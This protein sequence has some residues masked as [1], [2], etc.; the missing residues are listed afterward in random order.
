MFNPSNLYAEKVFA[1]HPLRLWS[2]DDNADYIDLTG[3]NHDIFSWEVSGGTAEAA[4]NFPNSPFEN[5]SVTLINPTL[6]S[7]GYSEVTLYGNISINPNTLNKTLSTFSMGTYIY[8]DTPYIESATIGY[9]Y[10]DHAKETYATVEKKYETN[11]NDNW[12][13]ISE[14]F[15]APTLSHITDSVVPFIKIGYVVVPNTDISHHKFYQ[16]GFSLGQWAENFHTSSLGI[17]PSAFPSD[18]NL[19][20]D[21]AV[22]AKTYGL[23]ESNAYYLV[24]DNALMAQNV[25]IPLVFGST[26]ITKVL[27]NDGKPSLVLPGCGILNSVGQHKEQTVEFWISVHSNTTIDRKI[28]GPINSDDGIYVNGPFMVLKINDHIGSHYVGKWERPMLVDLRI[29]HNTASLMIN[30][31]QVIELTFMTNELSLPLEYVNGKSQDWLGFYAYEDVPQLEVDCVAIYPYQVPSVVAKRR[32]VYGQGVEFPENIN[33]AYSGTS[34]YIDYPFAEYSNNYTYPDL[35][36]WSQGFLDNLAVKKSA[37]SLGDYIEPV[38]NLSDKTA[39]ELI[40][41]IEGEDLPFTF[42]PNSTW[43][44]VNGNIFIEKFNLLNRD[45]DCI[46][47]IFKRVE[48]ESSTQT[49]I[50]IENSLTGEHFSIDIVDN[51]IVYSLSGQAIYTAY[52]TAIN[53]KFAVGLKVSDFVSYFGGSVAAFFGNRSALS[54]YVGGTKEFTNTFTG[55]IYTFALC[56]SRNFRGAVGFFDAR[57][58]PMDYLNIF[59]TYPEY[60]EIDADANPFASGGYYDANDVFVKVSPSFWTYYISGGIVSTFLPQFLSQHVPSYKLSITSRFGKKKFGVSIDGYWEDH[61]PLTYFAKYVTDIDGT[62]KY[63]LDFIQFNIDYPAPSLF[64]KTVERSSW[65]YQEL[66]QKYSSPIQRQY[67]SLDNQ[68]FTGYADY[69][70]LSNNLTTRYSYDT[71]KSKVK[72]YVTFQYLSTGAN[73]PE[74][75]FIDIVPLSNNGIVRPGAEWMTT[76]YEVVDNAIIYPPRGIDLKTLALVTHIHVSVDDVVS[77]P[78]T[79]RSLQYASQT[80][81]AGGDNKIGTRFGVPIYPYK[82]SGIYFDYKSENPYSI[83]KGSSPHLYLTRDSGI[84]LRGDYDPLIN[85]GILIPINQNQADGYKVMAMQMYLRYNQ[86]SFEALPVEIFEIESKSG[87]IKFF[88]EANSDTGNRARIYAIN[89]QTGQIEDGITFYWNGQLV[90]EPIMTIREWGLLGISFSNVLNF[91]NFAGSIRINGPILFNNVSYYQSTNLQ[92]VQKVTSRPWFRVQYSGQLELDW[93]Y[94]AEAYLWRGM[95]VISST[96]YYGVN[97]SDIYKAFTGTNK[98]IIEDDSVFQFGGYQYAAYQDITWQS[99]IQNPV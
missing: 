84:E 22:P 75:A 95:L 40:N 53:E 68:L 42:R 30:G 85:R 79:I 3:G 8:S 98:I 35:G 70:D 59:E 21:L 76:M 54:V 24:K 86:N 17:V 87:I 63:D 31:E 51:S 11:L 90:K 73:S 71:T 10:Y 52:P 62:Q 55:K 28:F 92:E 19:E 97:P 78:I 41:L 44:S 5:S 39:E 69:E 56:S 60:V 48:H 13:F 26:N 96:S 18:I 14:T 83:Y 47:G 64:M 43:N 38:I 65:T 58:L 89:A 46:Y 12:F 80:L 32:F 37:L 29:G 16:N 27:A 66:N 20:Q 61:I 91:V 94:W 7:E 93:N 67:D 9:R 49:L 23:S 25:G 99:Q 15:D 81:N 34:M 36:K 4:V 6:P 74:S 1:E 33:T 57:G 2:L 88:M 77:N 50:R 45:T 72:T 82:K